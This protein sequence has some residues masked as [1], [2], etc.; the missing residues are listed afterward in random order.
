MARSRGPLGF[1][2]SNLDRGSREDVS[3]GAYARRQL[4]RRI[5]LGVFG[6]LL[7]GGALVLYYELRPPRTASSDDHYAVRVRC[8]SCGHSMTTRVPHTQTFPMKCPSCRKPTCQ[9][10][11][12]CRDCDAEFVPEQTG[13][14]VHCPQCGSERVGSATQP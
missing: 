13:G 10:L 1:D 7:M 3:I 6:L 11:W 12:Q 4:R 9:P 2:A 8:L 5:L 14:V